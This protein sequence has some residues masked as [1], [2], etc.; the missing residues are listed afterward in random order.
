MAKF[1]ELE[2]VVITSVLTWNSRFLKVPF[3]HST[4]RIGKNQEKYKDKR[5]VDLDL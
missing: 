4:G 2:I 3:S 1:G 5:F